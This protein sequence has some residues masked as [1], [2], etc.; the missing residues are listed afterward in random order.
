MT[1]KY[2]LWFNQ[3]RLQDIPLVGGKNASL[4]EMFRNL[5]SKGIS[6]P[7]GFAVTAEAYNHFI[8]NA[9]IK[10]LIKKS[11]ESLD[12]KNVKSLQQTGKEVRSLIQ[13]SEFSEELRS[14]ITQA[15]RQLCKQYGNMC[16]VAVRSSATAEDLP[17]AS[18]A[19]QQETYLN[20]RGESAVI[21]SCKKCFAS[22]FTDR[23]IS[24]R[25]DKKYSHFKVALSIGIQKMVRSDKA[26]S[27]VMF[28]IDTETGFNK[29]VL[30]NS[31]Y[32]LGENIVKGTVNPDEFV[33]FKPTLA[34]G[35][36]SILSKQRGNKQIKMLYSSGK[37]ST[38]NVPVPSQDRMKFSLSD[39][40]VVTLAKWGVIIED[41]Y[42]KKAKHY[43]PMDIEWAKDGVSNKLYI[44]QARPETIQSQKPKTII[45]QHILKRKSQIIC[46]GHSVGEKIGSGKAHIITSVHNI[47][48]FKP[49]EVLVTETTDPDWEP[50]MKI[51]SAIVTNKGGRTSHAAI[52]SR[53]LG[54]PCVV[55]TVNA[56]KLIKNNTPVTVSCAEGDQG[57]IYKG[58]L[59]F[60]KKTINLAKV[61]KL[62]VN[63]MLNLGTPESAFTDASLPVNGI[64]LAR[65]EFII[66]AYIKIH[67]Q[68][69]LN[70]NTLK[71]QKAK[72]II[73]N[74]TQEYKDKSQFFI[75]KLAEG[76]ALLAA[77]FYPHDVI[78]RL[79]D[80]K[81]NEYANLIGG[82]EFEPHE[83]N[84]MIGFRGA[85]RYYSPQY[86]DAFRLECLAIKKVREQQGLTN[87]K[88]M[89]PFCRTPQEGQ[90]VIAEMEKSGLKRNKNGL[91]IYVM[92]EIPS[93][94]ILAE[95]FAKIFDGFSIGTN[96]LTQLTL[97]LDRDSALVA[98]L[99]DE[100]NP[101]VKELISQVIR[102]CKKFKCKI[103]ICGDAPSTY[104]DFADFLVK[105]GI[106]S[107]SLSPDAVVKTIMH[108]AKMRK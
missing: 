81:S 26:S 14:Q 59:P 19:G 82:R 18:F 98:H 73:A 7:N 93:N 9:G 43:K 105:E 5:T 69:L 44:V 61:P 25:V 87:V 104:P 65:L 2:I 66:N 94:V 24:Y 64:G 80:F 11:L 102:K 47:N 72:K 30:I 38:Q 100:R 36:N 48:K 28:T 71:D 35:Y 60:I 79:S 39:S 45:E 22:L 15:Y 77:A 97:G 95:Q 12:I 21:D 56:T 46:T 13:N 76:V 101:A 20:I 63:I 31:S 75:D 23:A 42:S 4:G 17:D 83:E 51:A 27:G 54:L 78:V 10:K 106:D 8:D 3:I 108:V 88:V 89:I 34:Q 96:D 67:P 74:M 33:V 99:Y 70:F 37:N 90:R 92:C 107:M 85:S 57:K 50:V 41:Y 29:V 16:D 53:E 49:G 6:I 55:G 86:R 91:E 103:G 58:I 84:P 68:A 52:V 32:G 1:K 40:E 62:P